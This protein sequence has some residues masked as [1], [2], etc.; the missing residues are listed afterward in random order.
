MAPGISLV[1]PEFDL[2]PEQEQVASAP[3]DSRQ[4]VLAGPGAGKSEVVGER[5]RRLLNHDVYPE[6]ILLISFSNAA[7][8]VVRSRTEDVVDEGRGVDTATIDSLAARIRRALEQSEPAFTTYDESI[9]KATR[10]LEQSGELAFPDIRHV[11]VDE[12]QDVV[13][14]RAQFLL[15]LLEHGLAGGVGFTLLG[16]PLQSLYDFQLSGEQAWS[17]D[18]FLDE[19]RLRFTVDEVFLAGEY[20]GR[21]AEARAVARVRPSLTSL[22]DDERR[23]RLDHLG[24]DL[25]P[26]GQVDEDLA[27]DIR[28]WTG[29]TA[30]LTD[31]NARAGLV[32]S[33]LADLGVPVELAASATDPALAPWLGALLGGWATSS[34]D[35]ESFLE[36]AES[37]GL[38]DAGNLWKALVRVAGSRHGLD[39][40]DLG[41]GLRTRRYPPELLR[42][43]TA[44]VVAS[45][46]HRAKGLEFD[47]VVL[48]DPAAWT[49]D[50]DGPAARRLFVAM[51]RA[52]SRLSR[53][54]GTPTRGWRRDLASG[55]WLHVA[56]RG[57]GTLGVLMEPCHARALGPVG[58]PLDCIVGRAVTWTSAEDWVTVDGR[59]VPSW[60]ALVDGVEVGRT[61]EAF[62]SWIRRLSSGGRVPAL[63]GARVSGLETVVG[64]SG[65]T[66]TGPHGFWVGARISGP[67]SFDWE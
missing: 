8:R 47:N 6:E 49:G 22:S 39:L 60:T 26:L 21:T 65:H 31:T 34:V 62:G 42:V 35:R 36:M 45:T 44:R 12:V 58:H 3:A 43:P 13:G 30:L 14:I 61:G 15:A 16:D 66:G 48:V 57:R 4:I 50:D 19:I 24:A 32:A 10:L 5:C 1:T 25:P 38:A 20:R 18:R 53:C 11:V 51:S 40:A 7:V 33:Q 56:P 55:A 27:Y 52:R 29:T 2:D 28:A 67:T 9:R 54:H 63:R 46:V 41:A 23:H 17:S 64:P 59:E 37:C